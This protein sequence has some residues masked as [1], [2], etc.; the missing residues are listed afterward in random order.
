ML[1]DKPHVVWGTRYCPVCK[2]GFRRP[3]YTSTVDDITHR[4][5]TTAICPI[6]GSTVG[7]SWIY[8]KPK[9]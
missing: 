1:T 8:L 7:E 2:D 9:D 3:E 4:M 6:C 5:D